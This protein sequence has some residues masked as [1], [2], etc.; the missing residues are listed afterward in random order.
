MKLEWLPAA[1]ADRDAIYDYVS[2]D[3]RRAA[4][5]VDQTIEQQA[6][7]LVEYPFRGR[8]GRQPQTRELVV[9]GAPYIVVYQPWSESILIL[10]VLH[11][12]QS[13]PG[14]SGGPSSIQD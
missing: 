1:L 10:R 5:Q 2:A 8:I 4:I 14:Q 12:A 11:A 9:L 3:S 6:E 7:R 13:W